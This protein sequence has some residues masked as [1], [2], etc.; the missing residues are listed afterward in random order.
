LIADSFLVNLL[1]QPTADFTVDSVIKLNTDVRLL[2]NSSSEIS[3]DWDFGNQTF[4]TLETPQAYFGQEGDYRI[5]LEVLNVEGCSDTI[6]KPVTVSNGLMLFVPNSFTPNGDLKNDN[7]I[8]SAQ[9]FS[10]FELNI[11]NLY[12]TNLFST[13]DPSIGWDGTFNGK[14]VQKGNYVVTIFAV[15]IFGRVYN[16]NKNIILIK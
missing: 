4:S 16:R 7:F 13:T 6:S 8:V 12:G 1:P 11:Y 14:E 5:T 9:N 10:T 15:D 3:W 2:N